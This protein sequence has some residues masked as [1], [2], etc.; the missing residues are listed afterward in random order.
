MTLGEDYDSEEIEIEVSLL[1]DH[2]LDVTEE[3][4]TVLVY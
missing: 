1:M 4:T 3:V 2:V